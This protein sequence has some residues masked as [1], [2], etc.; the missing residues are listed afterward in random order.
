MAK[1]VK[2]RNIVLLGPMYKEKQNMMDKSKV[3]LI[4]QDL[5]LILR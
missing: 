2:L 3:I 1:W 4:P 5:F